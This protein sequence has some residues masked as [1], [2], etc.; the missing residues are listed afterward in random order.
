MEHNV[1]KSLSKLSPKPIHNELQARCVIC[2]KKLGLYTPPCNG[3]RFRCPHCKAELEIHT[4]VNESG[5]WNLSCS[6][7]STKNT[8]PAKT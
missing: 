6:V 3:H 8:R 4:T 5:V 2:D 1:V 7:L